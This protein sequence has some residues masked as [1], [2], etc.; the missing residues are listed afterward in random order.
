LLFENVQIQDE[1][2]LMIGEI[3]KIDMRTELLSV[4][5]FVLMSALILVPCVVYNQVTGGRKVSSC[6]TAQLSLVLVSHALV[7]H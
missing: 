6:D 7:L 3:K 5:K 1:E 4:S 2:E